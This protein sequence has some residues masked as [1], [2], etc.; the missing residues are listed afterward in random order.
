MTAYPWAWL[1]YHALDM[2]ISAADFWEMSPRAVVML[3]Q[4]L[5][6]SMPKTQ[7]GSRRGPAPSGP[8]R[9]DYIPRP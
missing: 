1:M 7:Q 2:G 4:E 5:R 9:L 3:H 8:V 6:H